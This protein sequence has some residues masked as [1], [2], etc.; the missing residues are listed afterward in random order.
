MMTKHR[1]AVL[2]AGMLVG[3][4]VG[5]ASMS[6]PAELSEQPSEAPLQAEAAEPTASPGQSETGAAAEQGTAPEQQAA[7]ETGY[8]LPARPRTLADATFPPLHSDTFP[9]STDDRPLN[10][11]VAAYLEAKAANTLLASAGA[12]GSPFPDADEPGQRMLP[13]QIA[14]FERLEAERLAAYE[15]RMQAER[16]KAAV[17]AGTAETRSL[18]TTALPEG[19]RLAGT[20]QQ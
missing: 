10:P 2:I 18:E 16:E 12:A 19:E 13:T 5:I 4:Q 15:Q 3:A 7:P 8:I 11:H 17:A 20:I 14:Y 1:I 6:G 9:P